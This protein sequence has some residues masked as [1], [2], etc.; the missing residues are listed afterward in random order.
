M[1]SNHK[2]T[3][4]ENT[5]S[6]RMNQ[7]TSIFGPGAMVDFID[8]TLMAVSPDFWRGYTIIHDERFQKSLNVNELRMPPTINDGAAIPFIRFP[9]WYFCP[10]CRTFR[11]IDEWE[12]RYKEA[13]KGD[14]MRTPQCLNCKKKLVPTRIITICSNGHIDDFPWIE[15]THYRNQTGEKPICSNPELEIKAGARG[16]G[17]ESI[18][19]TCKSCK[20]TTNMRGAFGS[21]GED[22][23]NSFEKIVA[24]NKDNEKKQDEVR[25]M[26]KCKG[27]MPWNG[28]KEKCDEYPIT[29]QRGALNVYFPKGES[30]IVIPPYS[31]TINSIIENSREFDLF[32][33]NYKKAVERDRLD[34]FLDGEF[35][36]SVEDIANET[37]IDE[38]TVRDI[39]NRKINR[40]VEE[41]ITTKNKYRE[42]E[43][44]ALKGNISEE[45]KNTKD[46]KIEVQKID[47]YN[48]EQLNEVVLVKKLREV[49]ALVGFSRVHPPDSNIFGSH[50]DESIGVSRMID[51]KSKK[52]NFYPA[53]E[54]RGEGIFIELNQ[55]KIDNWVSNNPDILNR[56]QKINNRY[57]DEARKKNNMERNITPKF[58]LLHTLAHLLI[59]ELSFEC[60]YA[61]ASLAER[62][63]CD[64]SEDEKSMSGILIYTA[65]GDSEGT[66]GGL[67]RQGKYDTLPRVIKNALER[68][69]WCSND[70]VCIES[71][72]Q[73]RNSLNFAACH[74]CALLPETSCEEFN[75]LLD[76]VMLIGDLNNRDMGFFSG[77]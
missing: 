68:S 75:L 12:E 72:G 18:R 44:E 76:R 46:F 11:P 30:S 3:L 28:R 20:A 10:K 2:C 69:M 66:L 14:Y 23:S 42:D 65:S 47:D 58:L 32:M 25:E 6:L 19:L 64:T 56:A 7:A 53:Y 5:H 52:E 8:Q 40:T 55:E 35:E 29:A 48:M 21:S 16:L 33:K 61:T 70:P 49:R 74:S 77:L 34:R 39:L 73:G 22:G 51:I 57:N 54:V 43:Y 62:I 4:G 36:Y 24:E 71:Q 59:R 38:D 1:I 45:A 63:Y 37:K 50:E 67:V 17:L 31:D 60:G 41:S 27:N 26:F 9:K 15:W 13:K